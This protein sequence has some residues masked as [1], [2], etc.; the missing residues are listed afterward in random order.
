MSEKQLQ[1]I[2]Q[3]IINRLV[4]GYQPEKIIL[5][6]SAASGNIHKDSDLDLAL[7]KQTKK[8]FYDRIGEVLK[9]VRPITPKPPIDFLIYTPYEFEQMRANNYFVRNEIVKR[10][11]VLYERK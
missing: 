10:G 11:K 5:F 2:L 6:G 1:N 3:K 4:K 7:I 9:I 8:R